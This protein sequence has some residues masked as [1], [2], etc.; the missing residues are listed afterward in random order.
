MAMD[1]DTRKAVDKMFRIQNIAIS[2]IET[3]AEARRLAK[4]MKTR[5]RVET[6][7]MRSAII[8]KK[9]RTKWA[10]LI[11]RRRFTG[12]YYPI[13]FINEWR[14]IVAEWRARARFRVERRKRRRAQ[15]AARG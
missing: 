1:V 10:V 3:R 8:V 2:Q 7:R 13:K 12:F 11:P 6:G 14:A 15:R 9:R 5:S 4:R